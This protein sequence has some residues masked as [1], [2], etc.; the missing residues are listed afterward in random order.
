MAAAVDIQAFGKV[1]D[2]P[3]KLIN[4][5]FPSLKLS[6]ITYGGIIKSLEVPDKAGELKN[7]VLGYGQLQDYMNDPFYLGAT[8]G[9]YGNRIAG[10]K[11]ILEG[12]K[13]QLPQNNDGNHLHGGEKGFHKQV[14]AI[15]EVNE[16]PDHVEVILKYISKDGEEGYPGTVTAFAVFRVS[17]NA[18]EI[19]FKATTDKTTIINLT[20]HSYFNLSGNHRKDILDHHLQINAENFLPLDDNSIPTGEQQHVSNT[21]FDFRDE[22]AIGSDLDFND[23]QI[24]KS[25]GYDHY[26]IVNQKQDEKKLAARVV[27]PFSGRQVEVFTN[28]PGMQLYTGNYLD[29][30]ADIDFIK[31]SGICL[32]TQFFPDSPNKE[33]F[34]NVFLKPGETYNHSTFYKF[35]IV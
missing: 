8:I 10:G 25:K 31:H 3:V 6:I 16:K 13:Y 34:S 24:K 7:I 15:D 1:N 17:S 29:T 19:N 30:S 26:F 18:V 5:N 4:I 12:E 11:F 27:H 21:P 33:K 35:S 23:Q 9:R 32:E 14:W 22:K 28:Y 2:L 20:H